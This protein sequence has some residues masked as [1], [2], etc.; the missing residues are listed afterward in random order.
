MLVLLAAIDPTAELPPGTPLTSHAMAASAARQNDVLNVCVCA[1][2]TV[3]ADGE[4]V[5]VAEHVMVTPATADFSGSATLVT[6]M[7]T[8]GGDG[9]TAGA[10]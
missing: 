1:S 10:M 4:I 6:M 3:T 9:G 2:E 7:L 5:F 8:V